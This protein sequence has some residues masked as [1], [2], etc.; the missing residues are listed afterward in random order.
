MDAAAPLYP[1]THSPLNTMLTLALYLQMLFSP[2][3][4]VTDPD[5]WRNADKTPPVTAPK[6]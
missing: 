1:L 5:R 3:P 4:M 2:A 6:K